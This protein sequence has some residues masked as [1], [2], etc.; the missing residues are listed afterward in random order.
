LNPKPC[1]GRGNLVSE[2]G[3]PAVVEASG[4]RGY[5]PE[6]DSY[7]SAQKRIAVVRP[8]RGKGDDLYVASIVALER[9]RRTGLALSDNARSNWDYDATQP[10]MLAT[11]TIDGQHAV[12]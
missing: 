4:T 3:R 9:Q 2:C 7:T 1:A 6:L 8:L 12:S 10:L 11:L 5:D